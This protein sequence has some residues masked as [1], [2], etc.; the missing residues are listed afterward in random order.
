MLLL[1]Y[2]TRAP[3]TVFLSVD[4]SA[5]PSPTVAARQK[6][7]LVVEIPT[8]PGRW[9]ASPSL[10]ISYAYA[11]AGAQ[12]P[13]CSFCAQDAHL[14]AHAYGTPIIRRRTESLSTR[15]PL[16][17]SVS[18]DREGSRIAHVAAPGCGYRPLSR[19]LCGVLRQVLHVLRE[20]SPFVPTF[21]TCAFSLRPD[22]VDKN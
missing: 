13:L 18:E 19:S 1:P 2:G 20:Q 15:R 9:H 3:R 22:A 6:R 4:F 10:P 8:E 5:T 14:L 7:E 21:G 17:T 11:S 12:E 16:T